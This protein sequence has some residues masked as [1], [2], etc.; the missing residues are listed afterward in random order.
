[1]KLVE[2]CGLSPERTRKVLVFIRNQIHFI[3][4]IKNNQET[5]IY[6]CV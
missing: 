6:E 1:M 2:G 5:D 3:E 4:Q